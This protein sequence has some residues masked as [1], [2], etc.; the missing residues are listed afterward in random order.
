M[1]IGIIAWGAM[2]DVLTATPIVHYIRQKNP[3]A[4]ITWLVRDKFADAIL[5]NP[6]IN[7]VKTFTLPEGYPTRQDAEHVMHKQ[8][9]D[10]AKSNFDLVIKG[11]YWP[12]FNNFYENPNE[13]FISLRARNAGLNPTEI[14]DRKI[15]LGF[16]EKD[17]VDAY[18]FARNNDIDWSKTITCNHISY[19]A[20]PCLSFQQYQVLADLL[21]E[22]GLNIVFTGASDE[23][24]PS[25]ENVIDARGISYKAWALLIEE[26]K[27]WMGLDSGAKALAAAGNAFVLVLHNTRD[28]PL[29]KT[30]AQAMGIRTQNIIELTP[31]FPSIES[32]VGLIFNKKLTK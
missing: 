12:E 5:N 2:C 25:G 15:I 8:I 21:K 29:A 17:V 32:L 14:T 20:S 22:K 27:L 7:E 4:R 16:S 28:F 24:I 11:Q 31:P 9:C 6:D 13:D 10:Y 23:P 18:S 1:R 26:S 30:G 19:A 3:I